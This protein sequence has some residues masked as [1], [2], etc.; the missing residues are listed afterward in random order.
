MII[1]KYFSSIKQEE[2]LMKNAVFMFSTGIV[3]A[4]F[5]ML[6]SIIFSRFLGPSGYGL[7][8]IAI[9][10]ASTAAYSL[11]L[12]IRHLIPRYIAEFEGK[13]QPENIAHLLKRTLAIKAI[14]AIFILILT[15]FF[16]QSISQIF[17]QS[18]DLEILLWPTMLVFVVIFL[19]LTVPILIGYQNFKLVAVASILVPFSHIIIGI[20][21]VYILGIKGLLFAAAV[22]FIAGSIPGIRFIIK[23]AKR[24]TKINSFNFKNAVINYSIP[25]Y[26]SSIPSYIY[27]VIIPILS[28]FYNQQQVGYYSLSLSFYTAAQLIPTTLANVMFPKVAQLHSRNKKVAAYQT[29][30][31]LLIIYTPVA[32]CGSIFSIPAIHPV[33]RLLVPAFLPA[34]K[35]IIVQVIASFLM[36]YITI[37]IFYV[38]A[39]NKLKIA[40]I[41][42]WILSISFGTLA[43]YLTSLTK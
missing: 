17:F 32:I 9:S 33:V 23:K 10:L 7:F 18:K 19:D 4:I 24:G 29:F 13:K 8:K 36:G 20:P 3:S 28:L 42:N 35:I 2:T 6:S 41:L 21:L 27:I 38:T 39:I 5:S 1:K 25:A 37:A 30:K 15:W 31:R 14:G 11:D 16:S 34:T 12:G 26:F 40:A 22:A 43:Y